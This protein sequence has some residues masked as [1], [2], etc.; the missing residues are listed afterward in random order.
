MNLRIKILTLLHYYIFWL[1]HNVHTVLL[2]DHP[3]RRLTL[4]VYRLYVLY[5]STLYLVLYSMI[6]LW[7]RFL[8]PVSCSIVYGHHRWKEHSMA[9]VTC[10]IHLTLLKC[11]ILV[12]QNRCKMCSWIIYKFLKSFYLH[13]ILIAHFNSV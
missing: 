10:F 8:K 4:N 2:A 9:N 13:F 7:V 1:K 5:T 3:R 11:F 6:I 12:K